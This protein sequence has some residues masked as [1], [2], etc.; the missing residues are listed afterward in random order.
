MRIEHFGYMVTE[1]AKVAAWY[2]EHLGFRLCRGMDRPPFAHFLADDS[3]EMMIEIYNNPKATVPD[4]ASMDPLVLH[5]ALTCADPEARR[6]R[7]AQA[8][9]TVVTALEVTPAGDRLVM[10]RDPWGFAVQLAQRATPM[11]PLA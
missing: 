6:D 10:L 4:Y 2:I 7:L 11:R 3:G 8:G 1:P 5:L 9:A